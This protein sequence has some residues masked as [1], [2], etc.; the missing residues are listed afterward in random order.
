MKNSLQVIN[1]TVD[2]AENQINDLEHKDTK[3]QPMRKTRRKKNPK[4]NKYSV[5]S[6]GP[7]QAFQPWHYRGARRRRERARNWKST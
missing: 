6:L 2:E 1:S 4:N 5:R 7:L 3:N